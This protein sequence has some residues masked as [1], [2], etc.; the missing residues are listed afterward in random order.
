MPVHTVES[1]VALLE[2]APHPEGGYYRETFRATQRVAR[3]DR[4]PGTPPGTTLRAASTAIYFLLP[5]DAFSAWHRVRSDELWHHYDGAPLE[6][7]TIDRDGGYAVALLGGDLARDQ[8][9]QFV[10]PAG[11]LQAARPIAGSGNPPYALC[12]CTVSPGFEFADFEL[13]G[14]AELVAQYPHLATVI[15]ALARG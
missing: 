12:G 3:T 14:S 9:P 2:L 6:L 1:L 11:W 5:A 10:V 13:P 4:E 7:H 8:R 15:A